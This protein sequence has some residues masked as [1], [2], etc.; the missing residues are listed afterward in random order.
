MPA[1]PDSR[2]PHVAREPHKRRWP[3]LVLLVALLLAL[4]GGFG[5]VL[6]KPSICPGAF[7]VQANRFL[8]RNLTFLGP[9]PNANV[10]Q[11]T[12]STL[13]VQ[14]I[15]GSS[16]NMNVQVNNSGTDPA[17]WQA[18][19]SVAWLTI[20]PSSGTLVSGATVTLS[21]VAM[22]ADVAPGKYSAQVIVK[23]ADTSIRIPVTASIAAGPKISLSTTLINVTGAQCGMPQSF[24]VINTGDTP[25]S[26]TATTSKPDAIAL[27]NASGS[28]D[29]GGSA[30]VTFTVK[31]IAVFNNYTIGVVSN[32]GNGSVKVHY[33]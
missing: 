33:G 7:C 23:T 22:P 21:V 3:S 14:A 8:H 13:T 30:S 16:T 28:V 6:A 11:A 1:Q 18:S 29:P 24:K 4:V 26:F 19:S 17:P 15:T 10:L 12:P 9:I 5:V 31:C 32:G 27:N 20:T 25:L 2:I